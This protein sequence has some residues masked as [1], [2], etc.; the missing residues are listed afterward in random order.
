MT[1]HMNDIDHMAL[2]SLQELINDVIMAYMYSA[3][4][5]TSPTFQ[6][7]EYLNISVCP[8][9]EKDSVGCRRVC[10]SCDTLHYH[11]IMPTYKI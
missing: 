7:C 1:Y 10:T 8:A 3:A 5:V 4:N 6:F 9:T 11:C 2:F